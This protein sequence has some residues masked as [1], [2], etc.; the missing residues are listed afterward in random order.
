MVVA[1]KVRGLNRSN[2]PLGIVAGLGLLIPITAANAAHLPAKSVSLITDVE[3]ASLPHGSIVRIDAD[4]SRRIETWTGVASC[5]RTR[6]A[7]DGLKHGFARWRIRQIRA[8]PGLRVIAYGYG[9]ST[10][11]TGGGAGGNSGRYCRG[12]FDTAP[13]FIE[14]QRS[15]GS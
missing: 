15:V 5:G 1:S 13:A 12:F 7:R 14:F 4:I 10:W 11:H 3:R 9:M 8:H 6:R 2:L